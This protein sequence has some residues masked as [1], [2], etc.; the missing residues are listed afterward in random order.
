[1]IL[2]KWLVLDFSVAILMQRG[3]F[4][5]EYRSALGTLMGGKA[6]MPLHPS[7]V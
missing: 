5:V 4:L 6:V 1:M 7:A 3:C 2:S